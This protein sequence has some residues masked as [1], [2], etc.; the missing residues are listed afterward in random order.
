MEVN[1]GWKLIKKYKDYTLEAKKLSRAIVFTLRDNNELNYSV[2][3][4]RLNCLDESICSSNWD[5]VD[6][7]SLDIIHKI[8]TGKDE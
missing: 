6:F 4:S 5:K 8:M 1:K 2:V 7:K 3:I